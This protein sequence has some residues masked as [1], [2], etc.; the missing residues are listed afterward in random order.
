MQ[1]QEFDFVIIGG[2]PGGYIAAIRAAH[3]GKSVAL[4]EKDLMGGTCLNRGCIPTKALIAN[5]DVWR[6]IKEAKS[7]G[8]EVE[9]PSFNYLK[10]IQRKSK[11]V[12]KVRKGLEGLIASNK[13]TSFHGEG[14]ICDYGEVKISGKTPAILKGKTIILATGSEPF[15]VPAFPFNGTNIMCSTAILEGET[16]PDS[17]VIIGGGVIGCEFASFFNELG[18]KV[19]IV[20]ALDRI[21]PMEDIDLSKALETSFKKRGIEVHTGAFVEK[22]ED[23]KDKVLVHLKG[24]TSIQAEKSL[25]AVG[26]K[27][28]SENIGLDAIG[29]KANEKGFIPVNDHME[30]VVKGVYAIG[31]VTGKSLLAHVASHQGV[32]AVDHSLGKRAKMHYEAIPSV[33]YTH[34]E[35]ASCG[36]TLA[37][38]KE[39]GINAKKGAFPF[40]AL[41]KAQ[42]SGETEGFASV[43]TDAETGQIIGAQVIGHE[44]SN[45]ISE[46]TIAIANE[47]TDACVTET[48][49]AHPTLTEAWLEATFASMGGALHLPR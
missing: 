19:T 8:I 14:K 1:K 13:I 15:N 35:V 27:A 39:K 29:L 4:I 30:T 7:F 33:T 31:D 46:M 21:L 28:N 43:V 20:E 12:T 9:N 45:L 38:A 3:A 2:G 18:T 42:A 5:A 25:V 47:L 11:I 37:Q 10:M 6:K 24:G 16:R 34:P 36:L 22:I 32:V 17:L 26:R 23:N 48:I 40:Q 49:H 44:A 41:G